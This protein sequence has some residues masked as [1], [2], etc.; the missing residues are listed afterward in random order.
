MEFHG[1]LLQRRMS[2]GSQNFKCVMC[3]STNKETVAWLATAIKTKE[4]W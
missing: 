1:S 4:F 3:V 2:E